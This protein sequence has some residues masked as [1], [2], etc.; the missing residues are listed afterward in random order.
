ML[1]RLTAKTDKLNSLQFPNKRTSVFEEPQV[2]WSVTVLTLACNTT[3]HQQRE[4]P[5]PQCGILHQSIRLSIDCFGKSVPSTLPPSKEVHAITGAS[6][7]F[8]VSGS[9]AKRWNCDLLPSFTHLLSHPRSLLFQAG[10][11][12]SDGRG[13]GVSPS[14]F[15]LHPALPA[16]HC[17]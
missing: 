3:G 1:G 6:E 7:P 5:Q 16:V 11:P 14:N 9:H 2:S 15:L 4:P 12:V 8:S 17:A 10:L 13:L